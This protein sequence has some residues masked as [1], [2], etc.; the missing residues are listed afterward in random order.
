MKDRELL[1]EAIDS[2]DIYTNAQRA[3]LK[4][5]VNVG[6]DNI[7]AITP[8]NLH[9]T[10]KITKPVIYKA[11]KQ[12]EKDEIIQSLNTDAKKLGMFRISSTKLNLIKEIYLKTKL[13]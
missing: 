12:F 9:K 8:L 7:A 3:I 1:L 10:T 4:V 11:L 5:L 2:Y 6:I 13:L